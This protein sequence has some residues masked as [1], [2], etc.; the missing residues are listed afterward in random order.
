LRLTPPPTG[1]KL[2]PEI[3]HAAELPRTQKKERTRAFFQRQYGRR[4]RTCA[5]SDGTGRYDS[6]RSPKCDSCNGSGKERYDAAFP[7]FL[8]GPNPTPVLVEKS[9]GARL[10]TGTTYRLGS[11]LLSDCPASALRE[12]EGFRAALAK[13][14]RKMPADH[15]PDG[16]DDEDIQR[17]IDALCGDSN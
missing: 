14:I 7:L 3:S 12:A 4:S 17:D 2:Q 9:L 6:H 8:G 11:A 15:I 16:L 13:I 10:S 1:F 5:A